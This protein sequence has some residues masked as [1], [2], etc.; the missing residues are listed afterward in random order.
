VQRAITQAIVVMFLAT[1]CIAQVPKANVFIG[2]SFLSADT[3]TSSRAN[4]NGWNGSVEAKVLPFIG[5]VGDFSAFYASSTTCVASAVT[6][7]TSLNGRVSNY[8]F[9]PR[10]S[11]SVG[12][13]RPFVHALVG[14]SHTSASG[15]TGATPSDT[16]FAT[17]IGGGVDF[18]LIPFLAWRV[19]G[20]YL[21]TR[22]F[23]NIQNNVRLSTGIVLRF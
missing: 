16:S 12:G 18:R 2:Y 7:P 6:C 10:A 8:L 1:A 22:F 17:A 20:D 23:G 5:V 21:Q 9:G 15:G 4:V 3:N 14:A 19:Q 11:F 13:V